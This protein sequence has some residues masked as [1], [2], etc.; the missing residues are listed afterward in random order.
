MH[1]VITDTRIPAMPLGFAG[2]LTRVIELGSI[3]SGTDL[4]IECL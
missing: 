1:R 4:L 2:I 3:Y